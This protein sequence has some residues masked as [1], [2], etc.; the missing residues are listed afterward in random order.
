M[1]NRLNESRWLVVS[2]P[3]KIED[4]LVDWL[5]LHTGGKDFSSVALNGY[6]QHHEEFTVSEQVAGYRQRIR[7]ELLL[8]AAEADGVV[9][10]LKRDFYGTGLRYSLFPLLE[11]GEI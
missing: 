8:S 11:G 9:A 5:L 10:G 3:A 7:F 1:N 2:V 6:S 4:S